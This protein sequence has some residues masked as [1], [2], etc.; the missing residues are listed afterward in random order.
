MTA[1][2][3][4][5]TI[6][7]VARLSGVSVATVSRYIN[8]TA[9]V[10]PDVS[11]RL[12]QVMSE[13]KYVPR[14]AARNLATHR[15]NTLGLLL[16]AI[17]GDFFA[18]LLNGIE[19]ASG[20]AG[21]DLLISTSGHPRPRAE[22]WLPLG[23]H[24]TDGLLIFTN[25]LD[26]KGLT[27]CVEQGLPLVLIHQS[28]PDSLKIPCV[29]VEN[30]AASRK[31]VDHL[32]E[33]HGRKRIVFLQ[34]PQDNEDSFWRESGYRE[35]LQCHD[36]PIDPILISTG[37][38]EREVAQASILSLLSSGVE[39]DAV[40][41]GDDEA[42]VGV[43]NALRIS[44]RCVPEDVAV[45]GFDDQRLSAF[46]T[47]PLTT[48]RAPTEKVG[49]EAVAQLVKLIQTGQAEPLTLLP[50]EMIIRRSCGCNESA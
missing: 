49:Y 20:E 30:K 17:H 6:R 38:F 31:I 44:K 48:V 47:P 7:D 2:S 25:T 32:I 35:S 36:I 3:S 26:K 12:A 13:L 50:T 23:P 19:A 34:G 28:G 4:H 42:A 18:P 43:L 10:S 5:P 15:T 27:S 33:A 29:T 8:R 40:Y 21:Y 16:D 9:V 24:N 1:K 11:A 22:F 45:V 41:T 14:A 37:E 46:L 39:F